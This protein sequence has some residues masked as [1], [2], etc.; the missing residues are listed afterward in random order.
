MRLQEQCFVDPKTKITYTL[1]QRGPEWKLWVLLKNELEYEL[2]AEGDSDPHGH[3]L[4]FV[5]P[6]TLAECKYM[7]DVGA[8][9]G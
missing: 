7:V 4:N 6:T 3:D 2:M 9:S 5:A 1:V 8:C